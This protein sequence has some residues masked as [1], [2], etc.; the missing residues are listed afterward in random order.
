M[1]Y[2]NNLAI[3]ND[4]T[5][6]NVNVQTNVGANITKVLLWNENT[7]KDYSQAIDISFKLE[8]VNNKEIFTLLNTDI[9]IGQF[10]GIYFLEFTSNHEETGCSG[11][12]NTVIGIAANLNNIKL[13]LL[14]E[15]L[16]LEVCN[17]CNNNLDNI[18]NSDL[19]LK[20]I[21]SALTLGYYEE[22]IFLY[23]KIKR[24]L[25]DKLDCVECRQLRTPSYVY[26][27]NYGTLDNTLIL[28]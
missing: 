12:Q 27:L 16:K 20:G 25:V 10:T 15:L 9:N 18:I 4:R 3:S 14:D 6:L 19:M 22:A 7:F 24:L 11:C 5:S 13:Y 21:C 1:I 2:I 23:K 26:G 17:N 8:Q 28:L